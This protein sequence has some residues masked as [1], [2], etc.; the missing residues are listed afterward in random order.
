MKDDLG[1]TQFEIIRIVVRRII[2][3][4]QGQAEE[5]SDIARLRL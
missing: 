3:L 2:N 4:L 5:E 1:R